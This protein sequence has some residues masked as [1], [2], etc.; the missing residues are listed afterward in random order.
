MTPPLAGITVLDLGQVYHG[1]YCG[2]LLGFF[3]ARVIKVE[4]PVGDLV[5]H[6]A[7]GDTNP[8]PFYLLNSNKES[9][10]IDLKTDE[11]RELLLSL[12]ER[13]DVLVENFN[14]GVMERLNLGWDVL[15]ERNPELVY[16][17]GRGFRGTES[18]P[19]MDLTIQ[20]ASGA[21]W[22]TGFPDAPPVKAG[23]AICD[24]LGGAHLFAGVLGALFGRERG[25]GGRRVSVSMME[26]MVW[27]LASVM[28][29]H[30]DQRARG[31]PP[32]VGNRHPGLALAP[33]NVYEA[34]DGFVAIICVAERQWVAVCE[35]IGRADLLADERLAS[36]V[37]RAQHV[38]V[39]DGAITEWTRS[40]TRREV[41]DLLTAVGVPCAPVNSIGEVLDDP[42]LNRHGFFQDMEVTEGRT[43]RLATSP[44]VFDDA[45]EAP[46]LGRGPDQGQHTAQILT[47]VAGLSCEQVS[48]LYARGI[49]G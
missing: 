47:E 33:Y 16:A 43:L 28:G 48:D 22:A 42:E 18:I 8:Y 3:G 26:T 9:I 14:A 11:G 4:Q 37:G 49:V 40:R 17:S 13:A 15:H 36:T 35:A 12:V 25:G 32:R 7:P 5:R 21:M 31:L 24:F 10:V 19:A 30:F 20:A 44:I 27:S 29:G 38:D 45:E 41:A 6:R 1:P 23:P 34:V 2:V 39:V 46:P